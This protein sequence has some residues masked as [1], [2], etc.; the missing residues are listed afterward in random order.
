MNPGTNRWIRD[1]A[2]FKIPKGKTYTLKVLP[3]LTKV[4]PDGKYVLTKDYIYDDQIN[5]PY[6][7][8]SREASQY[9]VALRYKIYG[10]V[11]DPQAQ[12]IYTGLETITDPNDELINFATQP[13]GN[14]FRVD[15]TAAKGIAAGTNGALDL[16]TNQAQIKGGLYQVTAVLEIVGYPA[17]NQTIN[18]N[19]YIALDYDLEATLIQQPVLKEASAYK[20]GD[21]LVPLVARITNVGKYDVKHLTVKADVYYAQTNQLVATKS[22]IWENYSDPLSRNEY[23][24]VILPDFN[25]QQVGD[26]YVVFK[27]DTDIDHPDGNMTNNYYPRVGTPDYIFSV[28]FET[29]AALTNILSPGATT[30]LYQPFRPGVRIIN[31]GAVDVTNLEL[32]CTITRNNVVVYNEDFT[33]PSVPKGI[34]NVLEYYFEKLYTPTATGTYGIKFT[35]VV[36]GDEIPS[37]NLINT[38]FSVIGGLSGDY[39]ISATGSGSRNFLTIQ[40]AVDAMYIRGVSGPTTFKFLDANYYI[41]Y[42][43]MMTQPAIDMSSNVPGMNATNT[44]RFV[45]SEAISQRGYVKIHI[46]SGSGIGFFFGQSISPDNL[47]APVNKVTSA[48]KKQLSNSNGYITFD[49]GLLSTIQVINESVNANFRAPFYFGNGASNITL[50]NLIITDNMLCS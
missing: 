29:E 16:K 12:T 8:I 44:V 9:P 40:E 15:I 20:Y 13:E 42:P 43:G 32:N 3:A 23:I 41:G 34:S 14:A 39:T 46:Q 36:A 6:V 35:L 4:N 45:A 2:P 22:T 24:D 27:T 50:K 7:L 21:H 17:L 19:F 47:N 28:A 25:P 18:T 11:G 33:I 5:R 37:N 48:N 1:D 26:Y 31:N 38:T 10:P 30:Y 49:G